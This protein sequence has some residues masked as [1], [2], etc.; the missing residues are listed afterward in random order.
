MFFFGRN[1]LFGKLFKVIFILDEYGVD[2]SG[3]IDLLFLYNNKVVDLVLGE[4][5][6]YYLEEFFYFFFENSIV[7][8]FG[9]FLYDEILLK[10]L[11]YFIVVS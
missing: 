10:D 8:E 9:D 2:E 1:L 11:F 6:M 3:V 7:S 4:E 5:E